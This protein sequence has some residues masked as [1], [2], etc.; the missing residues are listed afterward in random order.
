MPYQIRKMNYQDLNAVTALLQANAQSQQGGLY[1]EYPKNKVEA[2]YQA[3]T[4][5]IVALFNEQVIAIVFSFPVTSFSLP[6]I[7]QEINR[8]FPRITANNWFY[9]PVCIDSHFRGGTLLQDIYQYLC[10][11]QSGHPIAFINSD[12]QR[13]LKAHEKIGMQLVEQFEFAGEKWWVVV[14]K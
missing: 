9:G 8:R 7:A 10:Q 13:S 1:G 12:N 14:G 4:N 3:S 11:L 2:L 6:P 5:A